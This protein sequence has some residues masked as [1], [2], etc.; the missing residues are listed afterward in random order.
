MDYAPAAKHV[1]DVVILRRIWLVNLRES[2]R[3]STILF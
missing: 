1:Q 3:F 2:L